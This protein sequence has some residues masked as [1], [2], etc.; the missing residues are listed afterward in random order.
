MEIRLPVGGPNEG[1][2][3]LTTGG[4]NHGHD[5][6]FGFTLCWRLVSRSVDTAGG[7]SPLMYIAHEG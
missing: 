7:I 4:E 6:G 1:V 5:A 2:I 3:A